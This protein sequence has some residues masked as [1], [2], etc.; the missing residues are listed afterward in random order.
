M[1]RLLTD[2]QDVFLKENL[3]G[4]SNRDL[5]EMLNFKFGLS[6]SL[7]QVKAYK[8]NHN[9]SSGLT[10]RFEKGF[11]PYNKGKKRPGMVSCTSFKK[12]SIPHNIVSVGTELTKADGYV[13]VKIAEPNK[14]RQKHVLVWEAENGERPPNHVIV[15]AD[16][17][18][19]NIS[20][21]NLVLISRKELAICNK[22]KLLMHDAQ[23]TKTGVL[24][25]KVL[26][27]AS[28]RKNKKK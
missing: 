4:V 6:L 20:L 19:L 2:V 23:L 8:K 3:K 9:L 18:R 22:R 13:W 28:E 10:G 17:D 5:T 7:N 12:G 11:T 27:K 26:I 25:S 15:F 14:W 24:I 1:A 21:D 16:Q